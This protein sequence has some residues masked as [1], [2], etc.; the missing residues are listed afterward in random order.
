MTEM[1]TYPKG[2]F[3]WVDLMAK[4]LEAAKRWYAELFGWRFED[5]DT[6]GGPPYVM[7]YQEDK[8]VA[9]AG[10]MSPELQQQGMPPVWS[11]YVATDD[12]AGTVA[13]WT[14][15]GGSVRMPAMRVMDA[16]SM[17]VVQDPQGATLS[18]W[19]AGDHHGAQR[20]NV[21]GTF[22][23]NELATT[24]R[25]AA[26]TFYGTVLG[27]TYDDQEMPMGIYS[28]IL[29]GERQNGG[30][31]EMSGPEW[32]GIPPHW[33]TYFTVAD[34]DETMGRLRSTGGTVKVDPIEIP[35]VGRFIVAADPQGAVM[36][37]I[38]TPQSGG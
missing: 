11:S 25:E 29:A 22:S 19:Q 15:A 5:Q 30:I 34:L 23:W 13:A 27:W 12:L 3:C 18:L 26:K 35:E 2:V 7:F 31:I 14:D 37:L 8:T 6:R 4:D 9:G 38:Q 21:P 32:Q 10:Q 24:D 36:T 1:S 33:M 28:L 16:G 20:V 17:A